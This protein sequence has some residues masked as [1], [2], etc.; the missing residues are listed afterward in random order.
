MSLC[1][2][3][4]QPSF[5]HKETG[6]SQRPG[7]GSRR[8]VLENKASASLE[9]KP[10]IKSFRPR[11]L[12]DIWCKKQTKQTNKKNSLSSRSST[13]DTWGGAEGGLQGQV[14]G[15]AP[16]GK[17][18]RPAASSQGLCSQGHTWLMISPFSGTKT[19]TGVPSGD[20]RST[21][22]AGTCQG[23]EKGE[24]VEQ[25][26]MCN[27]RTASSALKDADWQQHRL[28]TQLS[29]SQEAL[30]AQGPLLFITTPAFFG[31]NGHLDLFAA[32]PPRRPFPGL[33]SHHPPRLAGWGGL[34]LS[35][36]Q[37]PA[38]RKGEA[39]QLEGAA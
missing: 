34:G 12:N 27:D 17:S 20:L 5:L 7:L 21:H 35:Q 10:Q 25:I 29:A 23:R 39:H 9:D 36:G 24:E 26:R 38:R 6:A 15:P 33:T 30:C 31:W 8:P 28:S 32:L 11:L 37:V 18:L 14:L 19:C 1:P 3:H 22:T 13:C 16:L 2:L 4:P